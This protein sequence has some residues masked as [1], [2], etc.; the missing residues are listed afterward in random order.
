MRVSFSSTHDRKNCLSLTCDLRRAPTSRIA[1]RKEYHLPMYSTLHLT[2]H[3]IKSYQYSLFFNRL[4][5]WK[6]HGAID[7]LSHNDGTMIAHVEEEGTIIVNGHY[8]IY[9]FNNLALASSFSAGA[10]P[11]CSCSC[12][13]WVGETRPHFSRWSKTAFPT[14]ETG[15]DQSKHN[16]Y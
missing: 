3:N 12:E 7:A 11:A 15:R 14:A 1:R 5:P 13:P 6:F 9:N 8:R 16:F 2:Q 4:P 10:Q